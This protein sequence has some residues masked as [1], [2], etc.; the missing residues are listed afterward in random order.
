MGNPTPNVSRN[1]FSASKGYKKLVLQQG[2]PVTDSDI[3]ESQD[4][5]T[6]NAWRSLLAFAS[7]QTESPAGGVPYFV[8]LVDPDAIASWPPSPFAVLSSWAPGSMRPYVFDGHNANDF[9]IMWGPC[10]LGGVFVDDHERRFS[11]GS[12]LFSD[13]VLTR[14]VV[15]AVDVLGKSITDENK[16][17]PSKLGLDYVSNTSYTRIKFTSGAELGQVYTI[18]AAPGAGVIEIQG[19]F[20]AGGPS[21]G[22]TYEIR[23]NEVV[24]TA[25]EILNVWFGVWIEDVNG[26]ED[27][28]L[29]DPTMLI[30]TSHREAVRYWMR[31][32]TDGVDPNLVSD[33]APGYGSDP[34]TYSGKVFW[35]RL[36][37]FSPSV[38]GA[39]EPAEITQSYDLPGARA[40]VGAMKDLWAHMV[41]QSTYQAHIDGSADRHEAHDIDV[42][43]GVWNLFAHDNVFQAINSSDYWATRQILIGGAAYS[44]DAVLIPPD[45]SID[46]GLIVA[47]QEQA[48]LLRGKYVTFDE[49]FFTVPDNTTSY[50]V[51]KETGWHT[52][53]FVY[54]SEATIADAYSSTNCPVAEVTAAGGSILNIQ[55]LSLYANDENLKNEILVGKNIARAHFDSVAEAVLYAKTLR[56]LNS[57]NYNYLTIKVI[58][59]T[60]EPEALLPITLDSSN[61]RIEGSTRGYISFDADKSLFLLNAAGSRNNVTFSN[62]KI[63]CAHSTVLS[64]VIQ[65]RLIFTIGG[66]WTNLTFE[67]ISITRSTQN[68]HGIFSFPDNLSV[69]NLVVC[70]DVSDTASK[71]FFLKNQGGVGVTLRDVVLDNCSRKTG[72]YASSG[73]AAINMV[74]LDKASGVKISKCN[75]LNGPAVGVYIGDSEDICIEDSFI[76][77]E[78]ISVYQAINLPLNTRVSNSTLKSQSNVGLAVVGSK[79]FYI[80]NSMPSSAGGINEL[81]SGAK[82]IFIGNQAHGNG[83]VIQAASTG[84]GNRDD[85]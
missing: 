11:A 83:L 20:S 32:T 35:S 6:F 26:I 3:N 14:G 44:N 53:V 31:T 25:G 81:P 17:F 82:N 79:G 58:G 27:P 22:D 8:G 54:A 30:E 68:V 28:S 45:V 74:H 21:L 15:T 56:T 51:V 38:N 1:N 49:Y 46:S 62:L 80:G 76:D 43:G 60:E 47:I 7:W 64:A 52:G 37:T 13:V 78:G 66:N 12:R 63:H 72:S 24:F 33:A 50:I 55:Q 10:M 9:N 16:E 75:F 2:V 40:S 34:T 42:V 85:V 36:A 61:W 29:P 84:I 5:A 77:S 39:L 48:Y 65:N 18:L 23:P 67:Q 70:R 41:L 59:P 73:N 57:N 19:A 69:S 4:I 71:D